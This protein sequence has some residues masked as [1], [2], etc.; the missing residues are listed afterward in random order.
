MTLRASLR[1]STIAALFAA[2]LT[3]AAGIAHADP[4]AERAPATESFEHVAAKFDLLGTLIGRYGAEIEVLASSRDSLTFYPFHV[5]SE[6]AGSKSFLEGDPDYS[7][8]TQT[9]GFGLDVQYRR[10]IGPHTGGRGFFVAPGFVVQSFTA[11]TTQECASS[12][13]YNNPGATCPG[14]FPIVHQAFTYFGPSFDIG[15]QAVLPFGLTFAVS[16]GVHYRS[17]VGGSLD[18]S[19]MPWGWLIDAGPGLRPRLRMQIGWAFL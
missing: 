1:R 5:S 2:A 6:A 15:G 14:P 13:S 9:R 12:Y 18:E 16:L 17:V 11:D 19:R 7:Y 3:F 10:Y 4:A 8:T